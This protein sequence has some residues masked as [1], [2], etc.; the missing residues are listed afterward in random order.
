MNGALRAAWKN[1]SATDRDVATAMSIVYEERSVLD[2]S[3]LLNKIGMAP[4]AGESRFTHADT[5]EIV[6]RLHEQK[7]LVKES[8]HGWRIN[9]KMSE[10]I[11]R[12]AGRRPDSTGAAQ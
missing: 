2:L 10:A 1:L 9:P 5:E 7:V 8:D 4:P 3:R 6:H 11:M 12:H